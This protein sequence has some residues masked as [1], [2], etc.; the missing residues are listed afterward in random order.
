[1]GLGLPKVT[2]LA[3]AELSLLQSGLFPASILKLKDLLAKTESR[4]S[5]HPLPAQ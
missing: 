3:H 5:Q 1:M 4:G 2:Q